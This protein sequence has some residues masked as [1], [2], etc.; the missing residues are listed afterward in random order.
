MSLNE[1][2]IRL[3]MALRNKGIVDTN[4]LSAF[5]KVPREI[6]LPNILP[7]NLWSDTYHHLENGIIFSRPY[8]SAYLLTALEIKSRDRVLQLPT[9]TGYCGALL[10]HLCRWIY[11]K[12]NNRSYCKEAS[13]RIR[14]LNIPNIITKFGDTDMGWEEQAPFDRILL[15]DGVDEV[16]DNL[17]NQLQHDGI[18]VAPVGPDKSM[19]TIVKLKKNKD[20]FVKE[21]LMTLTPSITG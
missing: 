9:G 14:F 21:N 5:E 4:I 8:I 12:D 6:F 3:I 13:E 2:P 15:S 11:T 7:Q 16:P 17:I 1:G 19:R 18:L 10:S 20:S